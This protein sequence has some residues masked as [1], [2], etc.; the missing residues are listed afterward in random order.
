MEYVFEL[1]P[2][3]SEQ[4]LPQL[5]AALDKCEELASRKGLPWLWKLYARFRGLPKAWD[6]TLRWSR[7]L[8]RVAGVILIAAGLVLFVPGLMAPRELTGPLIV[9]ALSVTWGVYCLFR[10]V[11]QGRRGDG[12]RRLPKRMVKEARSLAD[13]LADPQ[14][15]GVHVRFTEREMAFEST[16]G[17]RQ[18]LSYDTFLCG[19]E[20][21]ELL[22]LRGKESGFVLQKR[23]L[24]WGAWPEFRAFLMARGV[25]LAPA[26][27]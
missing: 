25:L 10:R 5:A 15:A 27:E 23:E 12:K 3:R 6:K 7:I 19:A 16:Q 14:R 11:G 22:L 24:T 21:R 20:T 17:A 8:Y 18:T 13:G 1:K 2:A 4:F 26:G 9:G